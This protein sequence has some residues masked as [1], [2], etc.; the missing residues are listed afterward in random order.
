M[1]RLA[2]YL[3]FAANACAWDSGVDLTSPTN[4]LPLTQVMREHS[5]MN[6]HDG[7]A[8]ST[9]W[10]G[11]N[12]W[13]AR[14]TQTNAL[15]DIDPYWWNPNGLSTN[16]GWVWHEWF[17]DMAFDPDA[18]VTASRLYPF[19]TL[20]GQAPYI[21]WYVYEAQRHVTNW[22]NSG[23]VVVAGTETNWNAA[24]QT[25]GS[26]LTLQAALE[27]TGMTNGVRRSY[28]L[29]VTPLTV[30]VAS[31]YYPEI[32]GTYT[33]DATDLVF[34]S[35]VS[36]LTYDSPVGGAW[37]I[38]AGSAGF[39][40]NG[41]NIAGTYGPYE[42]SVT[43]TVA[44]TVLTEVLNGFIFTNG[45]AQAGDFTGFWHL[46]DLT[47]LLSV[48]GS[49]WYAPD[50]DGYTYWQEDS[51]GRFT[52]PHESIPLYLRSGVYYRYADWQAEYTMGVS[53]TKVDLIVTNTL[54]PDCDGSYLEGYVADYGR[55]DGDAVIE[56]VAAGEWII[57]GPEHYV[58][59][60]GSSNATANGDYSF[61][62]LT[63]Y[64]NA[65]GWGIRD[66]E[67]VAYVYP[68]NAPYAGYEIAVTGAVSPDI[69]GGWELYPTPHRGEWSVVV[70]N[71]N[72]YILRS[73]K[74]TFTG[75]LSNGSGVYSSTDVDWPDDPANWGT[76]TM[77]GYTWSLTGS[78]FQISNGS[79]T[80]H[81]DSTTD[82]FAT[83][84]TF[85]FP[86][87][88]DGTATVERWVKS[89]TNV[90]GAYTPDPD[91]LVTGTAYLIDTSFNGYTNATLAGDYT[92][93][94]TYL[95][96]TCTV[97]AAYF[98]REGTVTGLYSNA[99]TATSTGTAE[100]IEGPGW[101]GWDGWGEATWESAAEYIASNYPALLAD[102][103]AG[104]VLSSPVFTYSYGKGEHSRSLYADIYE[105]I[106]V[107]ADPSPT[108]VSY[109]ISLI[110]SESE[111]VASPACRVA[112]K[113]GDGTAIAA[114][115][116]L[117]S[118][119]NVNLF[120]ES[121]YYTNTYGLAY[122]DG[123]TFPYVDFRLVKFPGD[124]TYF[125]QFY[126]GITSSP[127]S[128]TQANEYVQTNFVGWVMQFQVN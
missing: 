94:G 81:N 91:S 12:Y 85:A 83:Y 20:D 40:K 14:R 59:V 68:T 117:P 128:Y 65:T 50:K 127:S 71:G 36:S 10:F 33:N 67:A 61:V 6:L 16:G 46:D 123:N 32:D 38:A 112:H 11:A 84:H 76:Y 87:N 111:L 62:T 57:Y 75:E 21:G 23:R 5:V 69:T 7:Y 122:A 4:W 19:A 52:L 45:W 47:N 78:G 30:R 22:F 49:A 118:I 29:D 64:L 56:Q 89:G 103:Q 124:A 42:P 66:T 8:S 17:T 106:T 53:T 34:N 116:Q 70:T 113:F 125:E 79:T 99:G 102:N 48:V 90:F 110:I 15:P 114:A 121:G 97:H 26:N 88:F 3:L 105:T 77:G 2:L 28:E 74:L 25:G 93:A 18:T 55:L 80:W 41:E 82:P 98:Y 31:T 13:L 39:Y 86:Y 109:G 104:M 101:T 9:P 51:A 92:G 115:R 44:V 120:T 72:C 24:A 107:P 1:K 37:Y 60:S 43:G 95:G 126:G 108:N 100:V 119:T 27:L 96:D 35:G 63:N 73:K 54:S 58:S